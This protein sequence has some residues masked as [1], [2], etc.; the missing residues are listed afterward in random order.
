MLLMLCYARYAA[1]DD[2]YLYADADRCGRNAMYAMNRNEVSEE[3]DMP[4][5]T[6][7]VD[8]RRRVSTS[9]FTAFTFLTATAIISTS[10]APTTSPHDVI[11]MVDSIAHSTTSCQEAPQPPTMSACVQLGALA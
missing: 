10:T 3:M 8:H 6:V 11:A 7:C 5:E 9:S 4:C 2:T 1:D